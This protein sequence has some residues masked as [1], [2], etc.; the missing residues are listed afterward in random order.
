MI[1]EN[2]TNIMELCFQNGE[3]HMKEKILNLIKEF[4]CKFGAAATMTT[5]ALR[6][7]IEKL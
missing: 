7:E 3:Q 6:W 4:E 5:T 2:D 1:S